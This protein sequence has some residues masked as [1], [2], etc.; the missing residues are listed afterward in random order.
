MEVL[1]KFC[2]MEEGVEF[3]FTI[4]PVKKGTVGTLEKISRVTL[5]LSFTEEL[6]FRNISYVVEIQLY[7]NQDQEKPNQREQN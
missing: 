4:I 1:R 6:Y 3:L 7:P 2:G 5:H